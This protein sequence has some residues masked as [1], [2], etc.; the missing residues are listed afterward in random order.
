M[1]SARRGQGMT[2]ARIRR[3]GA[4][5]VIIDPTHAPPIGALIALIDGDKN[6]SFQ[7]HSYYF[8]F[9]SQPPFRIGRVHKPPK[10]RYTAIADNSAKH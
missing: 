2:M 8:L 1:S 6:P 7:P 4:L 10:E 5:L 9:L 3:F